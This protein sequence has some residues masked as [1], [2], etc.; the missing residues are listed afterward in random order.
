VLPSLYCGAAPCFGGFLVGGARPEVALCVCLGGEQPSEFH[1]C[2]T[3]AVRVPRPANPP[4][5]VWL[6]QEWLLL[7]ASHTSFC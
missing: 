5:Q 1:V 3:R 2:P 7:L 6:G 4:E